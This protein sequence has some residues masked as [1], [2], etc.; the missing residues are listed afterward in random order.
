MVCPSTPQHPPQALYSTPPHKTNFNVPPSNRFRP[1]CFFLP[2]T[3]ILILI[4][5]P[6][7][8]LLHTQPPCYTDHQTPRHVDFNVGCTAAG[9]CWIWILA[10]MAVSQVPFGS[11]F[12]IFPCLE[13]HSACMSVI[14]NAIRPGLK[15]INSSK[16]SLIRD[17]KTEWLSNTRGNDGMAPC[18]DN[19]G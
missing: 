10:S 1:D 14:A 12:P 16:A 15:W 3:T 11:C 19:P 9:P 5:I 2:Q 8:Q 6:I 4:L 7:N 13:S 17:G 18:G